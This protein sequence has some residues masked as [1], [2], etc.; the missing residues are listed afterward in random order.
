MNK[1]LIEVL[2]AP[3][4]TAAA[5]LFHLQQNVNFLVFSMDGIKKWI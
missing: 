3:K 4:D 1:D 2:N 5:A